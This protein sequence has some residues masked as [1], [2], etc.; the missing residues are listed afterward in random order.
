MRHILC[1]LG[2]H[3]WHY[4]GL[5]RLDGGY[6]HFRCCMRCEKSEQTDNVLRYY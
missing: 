3:D 2:W 6:D 1:W 5:K 4:F